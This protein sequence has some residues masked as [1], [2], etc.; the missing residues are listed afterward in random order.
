MT[1]KKLNPDDDNIGKLVERVGPREELPEVIKARLARTFK[2]E[3]ANARLARRRV[4][5]QQYLSIAAVLMLAV[6]VTWLYPTGSA[7]IPSARVMVAKGEVDWIT[8]QTRDVLRRGNRINLGDSIETGAD[9]RVNLA[10]HDTPTSIRLD[11]NTK[12]AFTAADELLLVSGRIYVDSGMQRNDRT[13]NPLRIVV[14]GITI[15]HLGTQYLVGY[16]SDQVSVAVREGTVQVKVNNKV[17]EGYGTSTTA[18]LLDIDQD[19]NVNRSSIPRHSSQW[20]WVNQVSST[21]YTDGRRYSEFLEWYARETG[22]ELEFKNESVER[23]AREDTIG[24]N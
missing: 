11:V 7:S 10:V 8:D 24:G 14:D 6:A 9:G 13:E 12:I 16:V 22:R 23:A 15:N 3:L 2:D 5:V 21:F 19:G 20:T 4:K 1:D 18:D 17:T